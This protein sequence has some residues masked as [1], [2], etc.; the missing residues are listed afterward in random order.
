MLELVRASHGLKKLYILRIV[1]KIDNLGATGI[2]C[3]LEGLQNLRYL[4]EV[5][6]WKKLGRDGALAKGIRGII[7]MKSVESLDLWN[8]ELGPEGGKNVAETLEGLEN[9]NSLRLRWLF[10][11]RV[12]CFL[13]S[14]QPSC[15][16][17]STFHRS[18][19][20]LQQDGGGCMPIDCATV[21]DPPE[22]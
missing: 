3:F 19:R 4:R 8:N 14:E 22:A 7:G 20:Q 12:L 17:D 16:R 10:A 2:K 15:G 9:L 18:C 11:Y 5:S 21:A 1:G 6:I 13:S